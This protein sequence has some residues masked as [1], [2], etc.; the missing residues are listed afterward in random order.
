MNRVSILMIPSVSPS[1]SHDHLAGARWSRGE[2]SQADA[3]YHEDERWE[4]G[5]EPQYHP[6]SPPAIPPG[7]WS[8]RARYDDEPEGEWDGQHTPHERDA[9]DAENGEDLYEDDH[10]DR[11]GHWPS[12]DPPIPVPPPMSRNNTHTHSDITSAV[13]VPPKVRFAQTPAAAH[14]YPHP[15]LASP[16]LASAAA[17][18]TAPSPPSAGTPRLFRERTPTPPRPRPVPPAV[19]EL[20]NAPPDTGM[21]A[22]GWKTWAKEASRMPPAAKPP[23]SA[24]RPPPAAMPNVRPPSRSRDAT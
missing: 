21:Y 19:L 5:G 4:H 18:L 15:H 1:V 10:D 23:P 9:W 20:A 24:M 13:A 16:Q 14:L 11:S 8:P 7:D 3:R 22:E 17:L 6:H 12:P 2:G